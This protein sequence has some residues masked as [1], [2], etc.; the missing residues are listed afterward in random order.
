MKKILYIRWYVDLTEEE[1][2]R[3]QKAM[4]RTLCLYDILRA[5]V[6]QHCDKRLGKLI[7]N[8]TVEIVGWGRTKKL[9]RI[10]WLKA[11][12][13]IGAKLLET[14]SLKMEVWRTKSK[15]NVD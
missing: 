2:I 1:K 15:A 11:P 8:R 13:E 6:E 12:A 10:I 7:A 4:L 5:R 3:M 9:D 14:K